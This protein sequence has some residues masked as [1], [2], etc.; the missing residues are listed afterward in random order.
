M[1]C[2][3]EFPQP[4]PAIFQPR[5]GNINQPFFLNNLSSHQW[6]GL[7]IQEALDQFESLDLTE[8]QLASTITLRRRIESRLRFLTEVGLGYLSLDRA[9]DTLSSGER[10]RIRLTSV[11]TSTL[12]NMLY[13]LDEPSLGLH[14]HEIQTLVQCLQRLHRRGNTLVIVDHNPELIQSAHRVI[15][16][17][18]RAGAEGGQIIF[19]GSPDQMRAPGVSL[20]GEY[21]T[22]RSGI[23]C[24]GDQRRPPKSMLKL[25]GATGNNL[26]NID[27]EFPLGCLG[28]VTG[29]SGSGKSSLLLDTLVGGISKRKSEDAVETTLPFD[30]L[31]GDSPISSVVV[32]DQSPIGRTGRSNPVTYV[33]AF[34]DI[35]KAFAQTV[36][37]TTHNFKPSHF[38]FN[39][40][41]GRCEKCSGEGVQKID[42]QFLA[43]IHIKC[44]Q[45]A[46]TRYRQE[47]LGVRYRDKT[48]A[49]VL[50][51]T[52]REAFLFFRGQPKVQTKLKALIDV[53]LDYIRLGQPATTLSSGEAQRLKLAHYLNA[54]NKNRVLFVMDEPTTGLHM[55]DIN[56]LIDCFD[57][58][59]NAGHS[60]LAIEHNLQLIKNADYVIDLGPGGGENGGQVVAQGTPE[61]VASCQDSITGQY[62]KKLLIG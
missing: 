38:S 46:G 52:V 7:K 23:A 14:Q 26:K 1:S 43:D 28:L 41:G 62:L 44:D 16:I 25:T 19:D 34:D 49:E 60:V 61:Q 2:G 17:G 8:M 37:A 48:I 56:R 40:S 53:G 9:V 4:R 59:I 55:Q 50:D 31:I 51:M 39:V 35:R 11:L 27:V 12:V 30:D 54:P 6:Y 58:L 36:D 24:R 21:L 18:P 47:V 5:P 33:K 20:T 57:T 32:V 45:C 3:Y 13:V 22:G 42:M 15:E 10:Q 29:V